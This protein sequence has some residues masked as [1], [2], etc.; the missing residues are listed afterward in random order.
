MSNATLKPACGSMKLVI[1]WNG[2]CSFSGTPLNDSPTSNAE[3]VTVRSQ[4][5]CCRTTVIS[6]GYSAVRREEMRT[7]G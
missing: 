5:W 4:N 3:S 6:P 2:T 7:P 1:A